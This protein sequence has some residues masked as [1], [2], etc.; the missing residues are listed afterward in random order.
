MVDRIV[1]WFRALPQKLIE[2][3]E[4]FS[5]RQKITIAAIAIATVFAFAVL[6]FAVTRPEYVKIYTAE[7][8]KQANEVIGLLEGEEIEY[9]T[10]EDGLEI[11]INRKDY[12]KANLLLGSNNI[13][14]DAMSIDNV[15]NGNFFTTESNT[16]KRYIVYLQDFMEE[17]LESYSFV[18]KASVQLS[19]PEENG[20]LIAQN[21][22]AYAA[23]NLEL[24]DVCTREN[25]EAIARFVATALGNDTTEHVTILDSDGNL[26]FAGT[27]DNSTYGSA[28]SQ[29]ALQE[30]V[31]NSMRSEV[32]RVLTAT[33]QFSSIEAAVNVVLDNSYTEKANHL[34]WP[35]ED[36][37][38]GVLASKDIYQSDS[39]GG[40][41]G[42]PG[43]DSNTETG[44]EYE[45]NEYSNAHVVEESYDY[46]PN[47]STLLQQIPAGAIKYDESS[48]SVTTLTYKVIREDDVKDQGLLE[49]ITWDQYKLNNDVRTKL[50][51]DPDL[52]Q[53]VSTATGIGV[54]HITI[55]SYEEPFFV[56]HEGL[57][58]D[59]T[60]ILTVLLILLI[61][62]LLAFVILRSMRQAREEEPEPEVSIDEILQSTPQEE[63][64]EIGVEDK[65][66]ARKIVEK[67][68]EDNPD[69]AANLLRNWLNEDI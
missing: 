63:L 43:T 60:D 27:N 47:E 42:V 56:D 50:E 35:D 49:G 23:V 45:D 39:S 61:L 16:Q 62:G 40:V 52:V 64:E 7:T 1:A 12:T 37:D 44:Y 58:M 33:N 34:Y 30:Q 10:S 5:R 15:T 18:N 4:K 29:Y 26:L 48:L 13:S 22:E 51:V 67:F 31:A 53:A 59:I 65:S 2:W 68:V 14:T 24:S 19:L 54:E 11:S 3:W 57:A 28:S 9:V 21:K 32:I 17:E 6:I 38:Q 25:A 20:T 41:S 55:L 66:E 69:A 8:A 46:L 36:K